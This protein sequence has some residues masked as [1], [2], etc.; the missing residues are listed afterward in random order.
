MLKIVVTV[1]EE[2]VTNT[3]YV[4]FE[5]TNCLAESERFHA[6]LAQFGVQMETTSKTPKPELLTALATQQ[7]DLREQHYEVETEG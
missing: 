4:G 6:L 5:G 2:S 7:E 1:S 3:D